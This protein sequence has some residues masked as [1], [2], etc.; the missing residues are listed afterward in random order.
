MSWIVSG[1]ASGGSEI[2]HICS[3]DKEPSQAQVREALR[4]HIQQ[5]I[6]SEGVMDEDEETPAEELVDDYFDG[7]N[8]GRVWVTHVPDYC[9]ATF[10]VT[11]EGKKE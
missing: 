5:E 6:E 2:E 1:Q 4:C 7:P 11:G 8:G 10:V 3:F 9:V